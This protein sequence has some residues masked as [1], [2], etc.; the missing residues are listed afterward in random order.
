[1][2]SEQGQFCTQCKRY[3]WPGDPNQKYCGDGSDKDYTHSWMA[4]SRPRPSAGPDPGTITFN[5]GGRTLLSLLGDGRILR[6]DRE[7]A[8]DA[9]LVAGLRTWLADAQREQQRVEPAPNPKGFLTPEASV[10]MARYLDY[11]HA[12]VWHMTEFK[13][14]T[15]EQILDNVWVQSIACLFRACTEEHCGG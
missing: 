7:V 6:E 15:R 2:E 5:V 14:Q 13:G 4:V 11:A 9:E 10:K 3:Q 12:V 1:M 8:T